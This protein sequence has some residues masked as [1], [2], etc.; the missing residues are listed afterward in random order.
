[1]SNFT[2]LGPDVMSDRMLDDYAGHVFDLT[3]FDHTGTC[4]TSPMLAIVDTAT[5][6][7]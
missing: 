2:A 5:A 3:V 1:M 7:M 4:M 6:H